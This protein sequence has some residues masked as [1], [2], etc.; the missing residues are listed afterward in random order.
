MWEVLL[1]ALIDTLK[2]F[3][4]LLISYILI[5]IVETTLSHKM[6]KKIKN[7]YAPFFGAGIGLIPQCGFSVVATDLFSKRLISMGTLLAI[8]ISTSDEAIPILLSNPDKILSLLPLLQ[9]K[10]VYA[11]IIGFSADYIYGLIKSKKAAT[12]NS[13]LV[14]TACENDAEYENQHDHDH[15]HHHEHDEEEHYKGCCGHDIKE[16]SKF[17]VYF[18][19]PLIHSLKILAYILAVNVLLGFIIYAVGEEALIAFL[20]NGK[21]WTPLC[22]ALIGLIPNCAA[23]VVLTELFVSSALPFGALIAGLCTNAGLGFVFLFKHNKDVK[24]NFAIMGV[25]FTVSVLLGYIILLI[26]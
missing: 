8:F 14:E 23:S 5:E 12:K 9:I 3:P 2:I 10:F 16:E 22:A 20:L 24:E 21:W 11:C 7:K 15:E 17:K 6:T 13:L 19:H 25:L 18:L 1:D 4:V 26:I